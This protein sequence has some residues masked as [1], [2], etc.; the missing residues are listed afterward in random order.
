MNDVRT[1]YGYRDVVEV[2]TGAG[3]RL[4]C[5]MI[6]KVQ[7]ASDVHFVDHLLSGL[8]ADLG[9]QRRIGI[10]VLIETVRG[11]VAI[12][13]I[14]QASDRLEAIIFGPGDYSVDLGVAR[15]EIGV[16]DERYPTHQWHWAMSEVAN[17]ARAVGAPAI[18]GPGLDFSDEAGYSKLA[19]WAKLLGFE[20]KWCIHPN[21]VPW[22][23]AAFSVSDEEV[24]RARSVLAFYEQATASGQGAAV[25]DGIMIDEAARKIAELVLERAAAPGETRT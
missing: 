8:E 6:P 13:D 21:Q 7:D 2:V 1:P 24:A 9:L 23:T 5:V 14:A 20:G 15:F 10:E 12:R 17:H 4:D 3:T 16:A 11:A 22:A 18:A 19:L 25:Y